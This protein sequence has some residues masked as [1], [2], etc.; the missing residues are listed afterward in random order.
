ML[1]HIGV[2]APDSNGSQRCQ[3]MVGKNM[4]MGGRHKPKYITPIFK[5]INQ[6][7]RTQGTGG[8]VGTFWQKQEIMKWTN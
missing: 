4:R 8:R 2:H 3:R 7:T 5:L 1:F 6:K